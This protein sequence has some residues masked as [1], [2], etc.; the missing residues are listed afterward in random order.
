MPTWDRYVEFG[1]DGLTDDERE[2]LEHL[3]QDAIELA[4]DQ[5]RKGEQ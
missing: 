4:A 5:F 2:Q 1:T 3:A